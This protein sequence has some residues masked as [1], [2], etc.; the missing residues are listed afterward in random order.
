MLEFEELIRD[1]EL[2]TEQKAGNDQN[3]CKVI[4][5]T[6]WSLL[7]ERQ[8][9]EKIVLLCKKFDQLLPKEFSDVVTEELDLGD[10]D[11][12]A[13]ERVIRGV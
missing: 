4:I 6:L 8:Y 5:K 13:R 3:Q 11:A 7:D 10:R 1:A 2:T 9:H 12:H